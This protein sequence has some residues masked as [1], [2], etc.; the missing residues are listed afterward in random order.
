MYSITLHKSSIGFLETMMFRAHFIVRVM[1]MKVLSTRHSVLP[2]VLALL[3]SWISCAVCIYVGNMPVIQGHAQYKVGMRFLLVTLY[4]LGIMLSALFMNV[5]KSIA[6]T[7][8]TY[9]IVLLCIHF[10]AVLRLAL[11]D[12]G[13]NIPLLEIAVLFVSAVLRAIS[14][15]IHIIQAIKA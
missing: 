1:M 3:G 4:F 9:F 10:I 5:A 7:R 8:R 2:A 13:T 15:I 14:G 12:G 11:M 6:Q